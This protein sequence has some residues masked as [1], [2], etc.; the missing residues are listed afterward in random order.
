MKNI[1]TWEIHH[2]TQVNH[3][4]CSLRDGKYPRRRGKKH[5]SAGRIFNRKAIVYPEVSHSRNMN[6][7]QVIKY[8][9]MH[10]VPSHF[11][12]FFF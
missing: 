4:C 10:G 7:C 3:Y 1:S 9:H 6:T 11:F 5:K 12:F 8:T 2:T